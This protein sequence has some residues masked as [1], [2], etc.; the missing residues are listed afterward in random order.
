MGKTRME[1]PEWENQKEEDIVLVLVGRRWWV[2]FP[3]RLH[4]SLDKRLSVVL[5]NRKTIVQNVI[6]ETYMKRSFR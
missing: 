2:N 6:T 1:K 5:T 4:P 3:F